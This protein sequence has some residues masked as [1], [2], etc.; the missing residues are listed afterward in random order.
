M[1]K[2]FSYISQFDDDSSTFNNHWTRAVN[3]IM[4]NII[5]G[6]TQKLVPRKCCLDYL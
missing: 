2:L 1:T 3:D 6:Q 5:P 4:R